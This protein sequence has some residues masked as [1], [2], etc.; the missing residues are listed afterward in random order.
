M[1][2]VIFKKLHRVSQLAVNS[3]P[4]SLAISFLA[5]IGLLLLWKSD[6]RSQEGS[7]HPAAGAENYDI[8]EK[9]IIPATRAMTNGKR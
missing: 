8:P 6:H 7:N 3:W 9:P 1:R 2:N 4:L 5:I